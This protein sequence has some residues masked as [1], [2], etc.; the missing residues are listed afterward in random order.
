LTGNRAFHPATPI[1]TIASIAS[2][3]TVTSVWPVT[4]VIVVVAVGVIPVCGRGVVLGDGVASGFV[5]GGRGGFGVTFA[6]VFFDFFGQFTTV[7][8]LRRSHRHA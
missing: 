1:T 8:V 2:V 5:F 6:D 3:T 7:G 4:S